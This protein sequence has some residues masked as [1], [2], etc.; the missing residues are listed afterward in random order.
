LLNG[1]GT[2]LVRA[3]GAGGAAV[4]FGGALFAGETGF[5]L[6]EVRKEK[7]ARI[8]KVSIAHGN[9]HFD[10]ES[11]VGAGGGIVDPTVFAEFAH[12]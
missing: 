7:G 9:Q 1:G 11:P 6:Q 8:A 12:F 3:G 5:A 10:K 2:G 4:A